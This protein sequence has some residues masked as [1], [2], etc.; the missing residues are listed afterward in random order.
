[1]ISVCMFVLEAFSLLSAI[2][3][4]RFA[5]SSP[6][7]RTS[8]GPE[9]LS[10]VSGYSFEQKSDHPTRHGRP[11]RRTGAKDLSYAAHD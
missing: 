4:G 2:R 9:L 6:L 7:C 3:S 1:M 5:V 11:E 10:P 8:A